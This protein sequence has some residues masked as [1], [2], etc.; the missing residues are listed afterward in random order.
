MMH[1]DF[2]QV[3]VLPEGFFD[4]TIS[5]IREVFPKPTLVRLKGSNSQAIFVSIL[6]H[7]NEYTGLEV[8]Q[9][10]LARYPQGLPRSIDLFVGNVRAAEANCRFLADQVD[11]NRCWPG[12]ELESSSTTRMMQQI[13]DMVTVSQPFAAI[14]LHNNTGTNPHYACITDATPENESLASMFN[15]IG[16]YFRRPKGVSTLAFDGICPALT[17]ECGLPGAKP[18]TRHTLEFLDR[19]INLEQVPSE[20]AESHTLHLVQSHAT[21]KIPPQ[22]SFEFDLD[23]HADLTFDACFERKNFN[24]VNSNEVFAHTRIE[25]PLSITDQHGNDVTEEVV[26]VEAGKVYLNKTLMPAMISLDKQIVRQDCLCYLLKNF[27]DM[28]G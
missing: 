27:K 17:L 11:F 8:M 26:R 1:D 14:D 13:I 23:A 6:L 22:V 25:R 21:L 12:T 10:L 20:I 5:N 7:G 3:T 28:S 19:L 9:Q 2:N 16:M 24:L 4:I 15:R 18:G